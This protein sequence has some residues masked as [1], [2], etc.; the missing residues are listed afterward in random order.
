MSQEANTR[1]QIEEVLQG[2]SPQRNYQRAYDLALAE[3]GKVKQAALDRMGV[4]ARAGECLTVAGLGRNWQVDFSAGTVCDQSGNQAKVSWAILLLH[5]LLGRVSDYAPDRYLSFMDIPEARGYA[6]PYQGRVVGRFLRT[7][8]R[9]EQTFRAAAKNLSGVPIEIG[10]AA[11]AFA[12][13]PRAKMQVIWFR[14]D[15]ELRPGVSFLYQQA[16]VEMFCVEDIVVMSELLVAAL[17]G[18]KLS[19]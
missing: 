3:A 4:Q 17:S 8:G 9:D 19:Q 12:V 18:Q 16:I 5:Y 15:Q 2:K 6:Q 1:R 10:D 7:S 13:F 11:Y 14:G